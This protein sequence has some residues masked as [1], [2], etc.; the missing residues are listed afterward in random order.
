MSE[1]LL[2]TYCRDETT[3]SFMIIA[4]FKPVISVIEYL[5]YRSKKV[6]TRLQFHLRV[7]SLCFCCN[8]SNIF[9]FGCYIVSIRAAEEIPAIPREMSKH[10]LQSWK[11][12]YSHVRVSLNPLL[13]K[14]S[15]KQNIMN[16]T[17]CT[18]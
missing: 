10:N 11:K 17:C 14:Y 3:I 18:S 13:N 15:G 2:N 16:Q 8:K 12:E 6:N 7:V 5:I 1:I 9:S 4:G